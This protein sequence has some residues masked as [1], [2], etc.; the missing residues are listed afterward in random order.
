MIL[1]R[2][3]VKGTGLFGIPGVRNTIFSALPILLALAGPPP[4]QGQSD[5][6]VVLSAGAHSLT[7]PWYL[8]P[9]GDGFNPAFM[10]GTDHALKS[11]E[12]WSF[13]YGLN[14]GF[15]QHRWWMTGLSLEPELGIGRSLPGGFH[16]DLRLGLG[17]LHYFWR[18]EVLELVDGR[19]VEAKD[20]GR[21]S[22]ILPLSVN[23]GYRGNP[24]SPVSIQPFVSARWGVQGLFLEEVP[25]MTHLF[26]LGGVRIER[27]G[28][29]SD[30]GR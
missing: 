26:L 5:V 15:F 14:I 27:G 21:P 30:E 24:D 10:M 23:L 9:V 29:T 13:F 12:H 6:P 8:S 1:Q 20:W 18:R 22:L 4:A 28:H 2:R 16:A 3:F 11:G 17:Y 7:T 25:A 19:Y